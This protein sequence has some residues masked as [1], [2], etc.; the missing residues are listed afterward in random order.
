[1]YT[2]TYEIAGKVISVSSVYE[3]VQKRFEG[4]ESDAEPDFSVQTCE[5]DFAYEH[6]R[7]LRSAAAE[8]REPLQTADEYLEE[9]AVYRKIAEKMPD[10]D[11][12]LF[13]GSVIAVDGQAYLFTAKSG[14][15]KS[16]HTRLWREMLG[17][18]AVMVNDDK[19]LIRVGSDGAVVFGTPYNGK[20]GLG[21]NM[22]APLKALCIL[23]RAEENSIVRITK[24]DAYTM[25]L[26]QVYRPANPIQMQK[27]LQLIDKFAEQTALYRLGCN[28]DPEAAEVAF[29]GMKG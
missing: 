16:T 17:D 23:T 5:A 7:E 15:G 20:H 6:E 8:H 18:R 14:T 2:N 9:L 24:Q 3:R 1:M 27:T 4:Y 19:P 25:L 29:N 12:F 21:C 26:Q 11:T 13:H 10:Y 22:S 28:M